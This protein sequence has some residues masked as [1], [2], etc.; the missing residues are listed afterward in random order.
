MYVRST[1]VF[2]SEADADRKGITLMLLEVKVTKIQEG[3]VRW[4]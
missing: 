2:G 4:A 3:D 1:L